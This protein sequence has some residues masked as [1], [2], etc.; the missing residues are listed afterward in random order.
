[1]SNEP[2]TI[3]DRTDVE[4]VTI[5]TIAERGVEY[6]HRRWTVVS[7]ALGW[8]LVINPEGKHESIDPM[9]YGRTQVMDLLGWITENV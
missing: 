6:S 7:G 9:G 8:D 5:L 2:Y 3:T 4:D 1:M